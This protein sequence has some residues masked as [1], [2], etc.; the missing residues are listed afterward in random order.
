ML[1]LEGDRGYIGCNVLCSEVVLCL[2]EKPDAMTLG[3]K[4][5]DPS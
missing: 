1:Y 4:I 5:L 3:E 2:V